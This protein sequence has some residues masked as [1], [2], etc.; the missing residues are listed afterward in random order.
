M[1]T[2]TGPTTGGTLETSQH[3]NY[4]S[5]DFTLNAVFSSSHAAGGYVALYARPLDIDSTSD[6]D[7]PG[8]SYLSKLV[9]IFLVPGNSATSGATH[10]ILCEDVPS[11]PLGPVEFFVDNKTNS[12][13]AAGWTL[14][15]TPKTYVPGA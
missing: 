9:G 2:N 11:S 13:I 12:P 7:A 14:K 15:C 3:L 4:P 10:V 8:A 5:L 6:A 1:A